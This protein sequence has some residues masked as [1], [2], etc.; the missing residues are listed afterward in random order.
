M[1]SEWFQRRNRVTPNVLILVLMED[2]LRAKNA[3]ADP[4]YPLGL[5]P[6]SNGRCSQRGTYTLKQIQY[7]E[8]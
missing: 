1:L 2:A 7:T 5:N 6:C 8:S 3:S 4:M